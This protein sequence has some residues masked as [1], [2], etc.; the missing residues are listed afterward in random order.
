MNYARRSKQSSRS[1]NEKKINA[2][3]K[4]YFKKLKNRS[5]PKELTN[6]IYEKISLKQQDFLIRLITW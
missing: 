4:K 5:L 6:N 1:K 3:M 2:R